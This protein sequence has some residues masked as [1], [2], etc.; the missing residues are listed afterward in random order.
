MKNKLLDK[1]ST[2]AFAMA[3]IVESKLIPYNIESVISDFV[4]SSEQLLT[5]VFLVLLEKEPKKAFLIYRDSSAWLQSLVHGLLNTEDQKWYRKYFGKGEINDFFQQ[6]QKT[7]PSDAGKLLGIAIIWDSISK[8]AFPGVL[9]LFGKQ[10]QVP[11]SVLIDVASPALR[12]LRND[13]SED[14]RS[15]KQYLSMIC[16][17]DSKILL[18]IEKEQLVCK[19]EKERSVLNDLQSYLQNIVDNKVHYPM[20]LEEQKTQSYD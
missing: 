5:D 3:H 6:Y 13:L 2:S 4:S 18:I 20:G 17:Y 15:L 19:S 1:V 10:E 16:E 8:E 9:A 7:N 12:H 14:P 11:S